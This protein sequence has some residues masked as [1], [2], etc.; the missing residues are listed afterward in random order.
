[1]LYIKENNTDPYWNLAAEEYLL[2]E[3]NQPIFRLWRNDNAIIVGHYQNTLAEVD[4]NYVKENGVKVVRR[5]T[6]GGAVF[7]DLGNLNFTF[8]DNRREGEDAAAMFKRFTAPILDALK[9]LGIEA[10][11]EGRNDLLIDGQKFSG[12]AI[13]I[14]K[15]RILQHG[16]L[17]FSSSIANLSAALKS[18]P[19]KFI[20]KAVQSTRSRV[21]NISAHLKP[22][23]KQ[24]DRENSLVEMG[25]I[26]REQLNSVMN[27]LEFKNYLGEYISSQYINTIQPYSYREQDLKAIE[28][29]RD[30]KYSQDSWNFGSSPAYSYSKVCKFSGGLLEIYMSVKSGKIVDLKIMGDYF[31]TLPTQEFIDTMIGVEHTREAIEEQIEKIEQIEQIEENNS[32]CCC[33][34]SNSPNTKIENYFSGITKEEIISM[35]F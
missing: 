13:C 9:E 8:I 2:K 31:F 15:N 1:M 17:L 3:F 12:N 20:G 5:L 25:S 16:T 29:L 28:T 18:R 11:L 27:I 32:N 26:N 22:N 35:F 14:H 6:G 23:N 33:N 19:E 7:H 4:I 24:I 10:T 34:F 21:T 30:T